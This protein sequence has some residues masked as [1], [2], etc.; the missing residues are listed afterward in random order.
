[1]VSEGMMAVVK[2]VNNTLYIEESD[3]DIMYLASLH[4]RRAIEHMLNEMQSNAAPSFTTQEN[5]V[6]SGK[7]PIFLATARD[8]EPEDAATTSQESLY[9]ILEVI[10][11][12][13]LD[14]ELANKVMDPSNWHLNDYELA[15]KLGSPRISIQKCRQRLLTQYKETIGET[16]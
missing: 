6:I 14:Y 5:L 13:R 12:L 7:P 1:M 4:V 10:A 2:L 11:K 15:D 3:R 8:L 9:D 16:S